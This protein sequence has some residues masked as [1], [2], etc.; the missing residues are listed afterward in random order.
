MRDTAG[1]MEYPRTAER[2]KPEMSHWT[3]SDGILRSAAIVGRATFVDA[4]EATWEEP[5]CELLRSCCPLTIRH[6][7][8]TIAPVTAMTKTTEVSGLRVE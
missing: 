1:D 2:E 8:K 7:F 6:T 5:G 3:S 4:M